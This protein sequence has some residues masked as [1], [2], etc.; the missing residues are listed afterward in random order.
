MP[1]PYHQKCENC[2]LWKLPDLHPTKQYGNVGVC[3]ALVGRSNIPEW[4]QG[5]MHRTTSYNG[6]DCKAHQQKKA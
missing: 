5:F 1:E 4:A 2:A 6:R 3:T